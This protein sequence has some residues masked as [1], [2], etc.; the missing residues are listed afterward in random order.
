MVREWVGSGC[1]YEVDAVLS[2]LQPTSDM[3]RAELGGAPE[4]PLSGESRLLGLAGSRELFGQLGRTWKGK[5][6]RTRDERLMKG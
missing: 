5:D 4:R 1:A 2:S 3:V 6:W